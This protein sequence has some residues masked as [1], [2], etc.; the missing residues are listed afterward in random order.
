MMAIA[1]TLAMLTPGPG[2]PPTVD[3][4]YVDDML[5][6]LASAVRTA[7]KGKTPPDPVRSMNGGRKIAVE[8]GKGC[9]DRTPSNLLAQR[10]GSSLSAARD[11]GVLVVMCHDDKWEC[12]QSTRD[13]KDVLC[14]AA[15]RRR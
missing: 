1:Y 10:A 5:K 4:T 9:S 3:K 11:A 13:P 12:H 6:R 15:P 8:M 14:L 2:D 7:D